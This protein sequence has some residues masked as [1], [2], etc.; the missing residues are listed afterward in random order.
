[1]C[2][3]FLTN[4]SAAEDEKE[5]ETPFDIKKGLLGIMRDT[6]LLLVLEMYWREENMIRNVSIIISLCI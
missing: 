2:L 3:N 5:A 6:C 4:F 1:M